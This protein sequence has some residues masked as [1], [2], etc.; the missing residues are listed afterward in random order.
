MI[1]WNILCCSWALH[2]LCLETALSISIAAVFGVFCLWGYFGSEIFVFKSL[3]YPPPTD[4]A[5]YARGGWAN[6]APVKWSPKKAGEN[7][8]KTNIYV[9]IHIY[10]YMQVITWIY[11]TH[12]LNMCKNIWWHMIYINL[13]TASPLS[14][15]RKGG[16]GQAQR[17]RAGGEKKEEIIWKWFLNKQKTFVSSG[18]SG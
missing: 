7:L 11:Y 2:L 13:Q 9:H 16:K 17:F 1:H 12:A 18:L 4:R 15:E 5:F 8:D 10:T 14:G 6:A 3:I